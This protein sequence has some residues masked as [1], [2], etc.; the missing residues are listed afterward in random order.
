MTSALILLTLSLLAVNRG[1]GADRTKKGSGVLLWLSFASAMWLPLCL[2]P[3]VVITCIVFEVSR[4]R[5]F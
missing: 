2:G 1:V 4:L 5:L 3:M